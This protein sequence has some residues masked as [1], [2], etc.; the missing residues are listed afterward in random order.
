[1]KNKALILILVAAVAVLVGTVAPAAAGAINPGDLPVRFPW[2]GE[3]SIIDMSQ[4]PATEGVLDR[5]GNYAG[6][7]STSELDTSNKISVYKEGVHVGYFGPNGFWGLDEEP[8][9]I[10]GKETWIE[11]YEAGSEEPVRVRRKEE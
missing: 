3:D 2:E 6:E 5:N 4:E 8:P 9:V 11:E 7:I 1:M 10:E